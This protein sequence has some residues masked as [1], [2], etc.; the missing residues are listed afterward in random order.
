MPINPRRI[1]LVTVFIPLLALIALATTLSTSLNT[2]KAIAAAGDKAEST[3]WGQ[4]ARL[5]F[6]LASPVTNTAFLPI[7]TDGNWPIVKDFDFFITNHKGVEQ[8][9]FVPGAPLIYHSTGFNNTDDPIQVDLQ[10]TQSSPGG[11]RL[12]FS[13]TFVP[14]PGDWSYEVPSY[15]LA[16]S[17][18]YTTT[19]QF[20]YGQNKPITTLST[21]HSVILPTIQ[22][23]DKCYIPSIEEMGTWWNE[24]PYSVFNLYIG[25]ISFACDEQPL[26]ANWVQEVAKQ[27][28]TFIPTWVGPQAPCTSYKHRMSSDP[29]IAYGQGRNEAQSAF[30]AA[31]ELG[32]TGNQVIYYDLEGYTD[33]ASC[34][35]T[36]KE[37][38]R[39]W[40]EKLHELNQKSGA[41][42]S[43]CRSYI[44]D[45]AD[46]TPLP[47]DVW[48]AHWYT[49]PDYYYDAY[50][51]V[52]DV[53]CDVTNE[54]WANHQR[55]KQYTGGH[56]ETWGGIS[57]II[58]SNVVDGD[59][60]TMPLPETSL[61]HVR[62]VKSVVTR[63][64]GQPVEDM[65][66]FNSDQGWLLVQGSVL[67]TDDGGLN[68]E[69]VT[70]DN[71]TV[72]AAEFSSPG[73]GWAVLEG[74][75]R[76]GLYAGR[77]VDGGTTWEI[78]PLPIPQAFKQSP[79]AEAYI[80]A[81]D[82]QVVFVALK[83]QSGSNFSLGRLL[84]SEDGG[85]SWEERNL[86]IGEP[87]FFLDANRGWTAGGP[88][89][90]EL[91]VTEDGGYNWRQQILDLPADRRATIGLP[92]IKDQQNGVIPVAIRGI[93][94]NQI[95]KYHTVDGG[96]TWQLDEKEIAVTA[97]DMGNLSLEL[98][99]S[100]DYQPPSN[101]H[102]LP[103]NAR[104]VEFADE[105]NGW[106]VTQSGSCQHDKAG[107]NGEQGK[108][109]ILQCQQIWQMLASED[110]GFSW[111][112]I[113]L[114]LER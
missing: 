98:F 21:H 111:R 94:G 87:V 88:A 75:P 59:I 57:L 12:I 52:W 72:R 89:G 78:N 50:A 82:E 68:W 15:T 66:L 61:T 24:S 8:E 99:T 32:I 58:D 30:T 20:I 97:L 74:N 5:H 47:D 10:I 91:Y 63:Q 110:G 107:I 13:G 14:A 95:L 73:L 60:A 69:E 65:G 40:N 77:T 39:G 101:L 64:Y 53:P 109:E 112:E 92:R 49:F 56:S 38:L 100:P 4:T 113:K 25:G 35:A 114:G 85:H 41:Y 62:S 34:R 71:Y 51:T 67:F 70:P 28:W 46:I 33:I 106:V 18:V 90:N 9:I 27:G 44:A 80:Q 48:I 23:F 81:I 103:A 84:V 36:V 26:D 104:A 102:S 3:R 86:P 76:R 55:I 54:L 16:Y 1:L 31:Q 43:P 96:E 6:D 45:W 7:I 37:F 22:G 11:P 93:S 2:G 105:Q 42:G 17:G 19:A 79:A 108:H 29:E 83:L